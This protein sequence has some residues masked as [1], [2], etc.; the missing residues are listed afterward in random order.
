M[1]GPTQQEQE[2]YHRYFAIECNNRAWELAD[3]DP[4]TGEQS[5]EMALCASTA[6][7]HW[8]QIGQPI[9]FARAD[10]LLGWVHAISNRAESARSSTD[11][12][13]VRIRGVVAGVTDW[14]RAFLALLEAKTRQAEHDQAG[15][16]D[17]LSGLD[18]ARSRLTGEEDRRA[19]DRYLASLGVA[20]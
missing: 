12:A 14:D 18:A 7:W 13:T 2:K 3:H 5:K 10:L 19:F 11:S 8:A 17:A 16:A 6:A 4:R 15:F 9:H 20:E 1:S